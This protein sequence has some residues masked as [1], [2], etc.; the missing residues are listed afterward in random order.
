M[1]L[2]F[3]QDHRWEFGA[4]F[5]AAGY[6]GDL[7]HKK[8]M[9]FKEIHPGYGLNF[10]YNIHPNLSFTTQIFKSNLSGN[11]TNDQPF[12]DRGF[13]FN[14]SVAEGLLMVEVDLLGHLR[15]PNTRTF[16]PIMSPFVFGGM[17]YGYFNTEV[18]YNEDENPQL[19]PEIQADKSTGIK[20]HR[21]IIPVGVGIKYD[22]SRK[23]SLALIWRARML[24]SDQLDG[25]SH[26]G[27]PGKQ[28]W[29]HTTSVRGS[30][31]FGEKDK[32]GDGVPDSKDRCLTQTGTVNTNGCPDQDL[33]GIRDDR[34][35][36]PEIPGLPQFYGCPDQ[37]KDG[38]TDHLDQCPN[39]AGIKTLKGCPIKDSDGDGLNDQIDKCP[40]LI[41]L[42]ER[43]GCPEEDF[44]NDGVA[45]ALD[46]CPQKPGFSFN[47]GC[48]DQDHDG[49][50]DIDDDCPT[51]LGTIWNNGCPTGNAFFAFDHPIIYFEKDKSRILAGYQPILEQ[52]LAT[53]KKFPGQHLTIIG[54]DDNEGNDMVSQ[55]LSEERARACYQY[56]YTQGI[57]AERMTA[58]GLGEANPIGDNN[59]TEGKA[60]NRRVEFQLKKK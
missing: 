15:Y 3:S 5:G 16:I 10:T 33:D 19:L 50:V 40:D 53:L 44:D 1:G 24:F 49:V 13:S 28:D 34:D 60:R 42:A 8:L 47:E 45:D 27:D 43:N 51:T 37:D 7:M 9:D 25:I 55:Q 35:D 26:A 54:Y 22:L 12:Q 14:S 6:H 31:R 52:V 39:Q 17:G 56:F 32:D 23:T 30:I 41:G 18:S 20:Q 57:S 36:C 2:G 48:P 29:Y 46:R 58:K 38:I 21:L 11:D 59:T 4:S